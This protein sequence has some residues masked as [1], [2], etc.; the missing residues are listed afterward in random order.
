MLR[1]PGANSEISRWLVNYIIKKKI[2]HFHSKEYKILQQ[3]CTIDTLQSSLKDN[4][5]LPPFWLTHSYVLLGW[6]AH[7]SED[8]PF[9]NGWV[10]DQ[11]KQTSWEVSLYVAVEL[12]SRPSSINS[13][14]AA[15][16]SKTASENPAAR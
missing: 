12:C 1:H 14:Q 15:L 16:L 11:N 8:P 7:Q 3:T 4:K 6:P 10:S 5:C 2:I 13:Q 9:L